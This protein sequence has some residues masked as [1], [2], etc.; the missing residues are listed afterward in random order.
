MI[1]PTNVNK[2]YIDEVFRFHW[3]GK[4]S[5]IPYELDVYCSHGANGLGNTGF[6]NTGATE[7]NGAVTI[8]EMPQDMFLSETFEFKFD[9][10][11]IG[12]GSAEAHD[13]KFNLAV[14]NQ[15]LASV[16]TWLDFNGMLHKNPFWSFA[17]TYSD[18][19]NAALID[20]G[21]NTW[22]NYIG[23]QGVNFSLQWRAGNIFRLKKSDDGGATYTE[24][25]C[26]VQKNGLDFKMNKDYIFTAQTIDIVSFALQSFDVSLVNELANFTND[27]GKS[28]KGY[29][30]LINTKVGHSVSFGCLFS[31]NTLK[32]NNDIAPSTY[33]YY[34]YWYSLDTISKFIQAF[35]K[36]ILR[37]TKRNS[38]A[39]FTFEF[40]NLYPKFYKQL[41][42]YSDGLGAAL[43]AT[44]NYSLYHIV[45]L[46]NKPFANRHDAGRNLYPKG[47]F[48]AYYEHFK[49][50]WDIIPQIAKQ[51][52]KRCYTDGVSQIVVE[53]LIPQFQRTLTDLFYD[54]EISE[55]AE[56]I[57]TAESSFIDY[58]AKDLKNPKYQNNLV[59][60]AENH[61]IN[62]FT[63]ENCMA[64]EYFS[65]FDHSTT[66]YLQIMLE[67]LT[68][69]YFAS[70][71]L[72]HN[73]KLFYLDTPQ[74][75]ELNNMTTD[76][77]F[78]RVHEYSNYDIN[79]AGTIKS[80]TFTDGSGITTGGS[81]VPLVYPDDTDFT[82]L[83][84]SIILQ[85]NHCNTAQIIN[86]VM[87][88]MFAKDKQLVLKAKC[89]LFQEDQQLYTYFKSRRFLIDLSQFAPP[90]ELTYYSY[91]NND[92]TVLEIKKD[93]NEVLEVTFMN[94]YNA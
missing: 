3:I 18:L 9:K 23:Y 31:D 7:Y 77:V 27:N 85:Q 48:N 20:G 5:L 25:Y 59:K 4:Q 2:A 94:I 78:I 76:T 41:Y 17:L 24:I 68:N 6:L 54:W 46:T 56:I 12:L 35:L 89:K 79:F 15:Y 88:G 65:V 86:R 80:T 42:D 40:Q 83:V 38:A 63:H 51:Y 36:E 49:Y 81:Y 64:T 72:M 75:V 73:C 10:Y 87:Y 69:S 28:R 60:N 19:T 93:E 32:D 61:V 70:T 67:M 90:A 74:N 84:E 30:D 22:S 29:Y 13:F 11:T 45:S 53:Q 58:K 50:F 37:F 8:H 14:N 26:G 91:A 82:V 21:Y 39:N 66:F 44:D 57:G 43:N 34:G 47:L 52:G 92:F 33:F 16:E 71:S 62:I 1:L 55:Y